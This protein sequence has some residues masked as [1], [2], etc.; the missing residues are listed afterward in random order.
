MSNRQFLSLVG[1]VL[2]LLGIGVVLIWNIAATLNEMESTP[3]PVR[4]AEWSGKAPAISLEE[5]AQQATPRAQTWAPDA[6]LVKVEASWHPSPEELGLETPP[7][8]WALSYYSPSKEAVKTAHVHAESFSWGKS[9]LMGAEAEALAPFPP[10]QGIKVAW[11]SFRAAGGEEFLVEHPDATV[12]FLLR[13]K[14]K[15]IWTV[16]AFTRAGKY[17]IQVDAHTGTVLTKES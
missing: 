4:R 5:A 3:V 17:E 8:A 15:M 1:G 10:P 12:Q 14:G 6:R 16:L 7:V 13:N 11:L 9:R 2:I